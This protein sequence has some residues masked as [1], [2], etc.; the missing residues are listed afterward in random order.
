[1]SPLQRTT[2]NPDAFGTRY[3]RKGTDEVGYAG[4]AAIAD[5]GR[6]DGRKA[7]CRRSD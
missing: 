6:M 2:T 5:C 4:T 7:T 3:M 1:M